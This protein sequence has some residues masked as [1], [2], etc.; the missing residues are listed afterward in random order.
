MTPLSALPIKARFANALVAYAGYISKMIWPK[1]MAVLYPYRVMLPWWHIAAA[2]VLLLSVSYLSIKFRKSAPY[3]VV[4]WL[5]YLGTLVPVIGLVQIGSQSM[6][7]RYTYVTLIGLF[8]ILAWGV[9]DLLGR[10]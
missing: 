6:A 5:W 3:F 1:K 2:S 9:P 4:G 10:S 7:D 8:I